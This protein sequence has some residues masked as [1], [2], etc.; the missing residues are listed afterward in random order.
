MAC[1]YILTRSPFSE[2]S[3]NGGF[4]VHHQH[5]FLSP[6]TDQSGEQAFNLVILHD[7]VHYH[8]R[9][10]YTLGY[11]NME[12]MEAYIPHLFSYLEPISEIFCIKFISSIL[13]HIHRGNN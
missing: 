4:Y 6:F 7:L 2:N 11:T 12:N 10:P 8:N 9:I 3:I 1:M 5:W 13:L